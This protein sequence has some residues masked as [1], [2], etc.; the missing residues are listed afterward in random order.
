VEQLSA[1]GL[2]EA[3]QLGESVR[4]N[5]VAAAR[6]IEQLLPGWTP[7]MVAEGVKRSY[8]RGTGRPLIRRSIRRRS[9]LESLTVCAGRTWS[10]PSLHSLRGDRLYCAGRSAAAVLSG[11]G[12]QTD[13]ESRVVWRVSARVG[14]CC[15]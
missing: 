11:G 6:E 12:E 14:F 5:D 7:G 9:R 4:G 15:G 3:R 1:M 10:T 2:G 8:D 13:E